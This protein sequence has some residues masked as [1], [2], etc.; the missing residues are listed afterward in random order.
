MRIAADPSLT[1]ATRERA[2]K[3]TRGGLA[4]LREAPHDERRIAEDFAAVARWARRE[5]VSPDRI[6]LGEFGCVAA[7]AE[8]PPGAS[9]LHWLSAVR[10][11]AEAEGF[12]W[13]YWLYYGPGGMQL[14]RG[15]GRELDVATLVA[16]GLA[17]PASP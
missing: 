15:G 11:A 10:R 8:G 7:Q 2:L 1:T 9:R 13:A 6:I 16:L 5:S 12:G 4:R 3:E 17:A 14:V